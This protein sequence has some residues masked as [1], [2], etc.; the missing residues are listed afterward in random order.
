MFQQFCC[1]YSHLAVRF[2]IDIQ[3]RK[4][5]DSGRIQHMATPLAVQPKA[6]EFHGKEAGLIATNLSQ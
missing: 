5:F 3:S 4:P 6:R 1:P 2:G